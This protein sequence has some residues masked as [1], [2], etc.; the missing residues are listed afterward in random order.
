MP[1]LIEGEYYDDFIPCQR[2]GRRTQVKARHCCRLRPDMS[3]TKSGKDIFA[4]KTRKQS[5]Y[6][7]RWNSGEYGSLL[8]HAVGM[9]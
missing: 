4:M 3:Q 9:S 2:Y 5:V 7:R 6:R 1:D 8:A